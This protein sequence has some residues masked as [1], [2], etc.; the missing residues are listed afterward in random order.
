MRCVYCWGCWAVRTC[1]FCLSWLWLARSQAFDLQEVPLGRLPAGR[2]HGKNREGGKMALHLLPSLSSSTLLPVSFPG[3]PSYLCRNRGGV[4]S[5]KFSSSPS[6]SLAFP[7]HSF[8][9][10]PDPLSPVFSFYKRILQPE[11]TQEGSF[12]LGF[13]AEACLPPSP[14]A[15]W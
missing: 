3:G 1:S 12:N 5:V 6:F 8:L 2:A 4:Q 10:F 13:P 7:L 9:V 14:K 15:P 11:G